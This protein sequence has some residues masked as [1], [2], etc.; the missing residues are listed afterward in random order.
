MSLIIDGTN[1]LTFP[2][3]TVQASAGQVLQVVQNTYSTITL[4]TSTSFV[5]TGLNA[6]ITPKFSTSKILIFV[7]GVVYTNTNGT[8]GYYTIFRG[9]V[10]G[11][12][13]A[14]NGFNIL[15]ASSSD[16]EATSSMS[17]LDSPATTSATTYTV[18]LRAVS[19]T[20]YWAANN[21][22]TTIQLLEIA[23]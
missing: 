11:T 22:T 5:T 18:G 16:L 2:N 7:N 4:T 8:F 14:T 6:T 10:S 19:G 12:N 23:A 15:G 20:V 1:G 21:A 17:F 3:S 9:T 13:L